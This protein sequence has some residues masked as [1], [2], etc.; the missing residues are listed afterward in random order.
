VT[1]AVDSVAVTLSERLRVEDAAVPPGKFPVPGASAAAQTSTAL[2]VSSI[3]HG[4]VAE[5]SDRRR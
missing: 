4:G 1:P 5:V 2:R 3:R